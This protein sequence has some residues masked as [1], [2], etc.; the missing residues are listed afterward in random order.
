[1][2]VYVTRTKEMAKICLE[3]GGGGCTFCFKY[4]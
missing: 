3:H 4:Q 2:K 1:M